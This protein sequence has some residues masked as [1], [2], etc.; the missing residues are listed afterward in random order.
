MAGDSVMLARNE[1]QCGDSRRRRG[2]RRGGQGRSRP[3]RRMAFRWARLAMLQVQRH[4]GQASW[5]LRRHKK[6]LLHSGRGDREDGCCGRGGTL[7]RNAR[8]G[9]AGYVGRETE[10]GGQNDA[11]FTEK[12]RSTL[13]RILGRHGR[14]QKRSVLG[15]AKRTSRMRNGRTDTYR[16]AMAPDS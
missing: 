10:G 12:K 11:G 13:G 1:V 7:R 3:S 15:R 8:G 5:P 6:R 4:A 14:G 9:P 16:K 2:R